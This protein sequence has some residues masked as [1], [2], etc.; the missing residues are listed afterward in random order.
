[1][2]PEPHWLGLR[3]RGSGGDDLA[4]RVHATLAGVG[5]ILDPGRISYIA[6][7][8]MVQDRTIPPS[9][10]RQYSQMPAKAKGSPDFSV[11][12]MGVLAF[13]ARCHPLPLVEAVGEDQTT[14][15]SQYGAKAAAPGNRWCIAGT[16]P[17]GTQP[18]KPAP[19]RPQTAL[20]LSQ[21]HR[22]DVFWPG[23][24]TTGAYTV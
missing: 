3:F 24:A 18:W 19:A 16:C 9:G 5:I 21:G 15:P 7:V 20:Q 22:S 17:R 12:R 8:M 2:D 4:T 14:P 1:M 6:S 23:K 10:S 13:P 11:T